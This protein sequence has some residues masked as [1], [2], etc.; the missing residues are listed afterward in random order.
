MNKEGVTAMKTYNVS[1]APDGSPA[2]KLI[3]RINALENPD[4]LNKFFDMLERNGIPM[5]NQRWAEFAHLK[6][7]ELVEK[8]KTL[9]KLEG[10]IA[11]STG[12]LKVCG[13]TYFRDRRHRLGQEFRD[14]KS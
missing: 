6:F 12:L 8:K 1:T 7:M 10:L 9:A 14:N 11:E 4:T 5:G 3:D 2:G 13:S